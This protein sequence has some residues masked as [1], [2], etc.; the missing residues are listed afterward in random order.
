MK[1]F[2]YAVFGGLLVASVCLAYFVTSRLQASNT[3]YVRIKTADSKVIEQLKKIRF[4]QKMYLDVHLKYASTWDTLAL[5][6]NEGQIPIIQNK[7]I[8]TP[9]PDGKDQIEVQ[10]DT[11]E[12]VSAFDSLRDEI[13]LTREQMHTIG[14]VPLEHGQEFEL[15]TAERKGQYLIEVKDPAPVNP[16]RQEGGK[17]KPLRFGSKAAASTK[18]NWE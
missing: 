15:Y 5:F 7:E 16:K 11:L 14:Q 1:G 13:G 17:L 18:G 9:G 8:V 4:A 2:K 6:I 12:V 10:I 3:E